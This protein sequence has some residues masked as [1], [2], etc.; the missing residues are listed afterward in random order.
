MKVL[1]SV[2]ALLLEKESLKAHMRL[3][4]EMNAFSCDVCSKKF[5]DKK[6]L[7][8]HMKTHENAL[9]VECNLCDQV[10]NSLERVYKPIA[11]KPLRYFHM[12]EAYEN[13]IYCT[14]SK[15]GL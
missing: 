13:K 7:L 4:S 14:K 9:A 2:C 6:Y 12:I 5:Q 3:H 10:L 1:C 8:L 11:Y 15:S